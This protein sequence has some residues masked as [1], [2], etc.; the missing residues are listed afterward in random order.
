MAG[1]PSTTKVIRR[2][3]LSALYFQTRK[4]MSPQMFVVDGDGKLR[5][6]DKSTST[7]VCPGKVIKYQDSDIESLRALFK[8]NEGW[9][10]HLELK[11]LN[12]LKVDEK[13]YGFV[14]FRCTGQSEF[15]LIP[16]PP[17]AIR[18]QQD[19][20]KAAAEKAHFDENS[21]EYNTSK[22][23]RDRAIKSCTFS[24]KFQPSVVQ[25]WE[26]HKD[27][28]IA[29][30]SPAL[31]EAEWELEAES[32]AE[33]VAKETRVTKH[34][35]FSDDEEEA[36]SRK[37][38]GK[39]VAIKQGRGCYEVLEDTVVGPVGKQIKCTLDEYWKLTGKGHRLMSERLTYKHA[40]LCQG[41]DKEGE[42]A[43]AI[44]VSFY[45]TD[46]PSA[47]DP[48]YYQL[49]NLQKGARR[50]V[51]HALKMRAHS[52]FALARVC[53]GSRRKDAR[54]SKSRRCRRESLP[55]LELD[56]VKPSERKPADLGGHESRQERSGVDRRQKEP[57]EACAR[58]R[59]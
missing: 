20:W 10:A 45:I 51:S 28:S 48:S 56:G 21:A 59:I 33:D 1:S 18:K 11:Y 30:F 17:E 27:P 4:N 26:V 25:K 55:V 34:T 8:T 3:Q 44:F 29:F 46:Q 12:V 7:F 24:S 5:K 9:D 19:A 52:L 32:D 39:T 6:V 36:D 54:T 23:Q 37:K 22:A 41:K 2:R 14:S 50:D 42:P 47:N 16:V 49:H 43:Q 53:G 35:Q 31:C 57:V 58:L 38:N 13:C 15:V 40:T